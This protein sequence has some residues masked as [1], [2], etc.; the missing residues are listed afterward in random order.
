MYVLAGQH[1][2]QRTKYGKRL[3]ASQSLAIVRHTTRI[4]RFVQAGAAEQLQKVVQH[5]AGELPIIADQMPI[6]DQMFIVG[7][8]LLQHL[9]ADE[10]RMVLGQ[11]HQGLKYARLGTRHIAQLQRHQTVLDQIGYGM[12]QL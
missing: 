9:R 11:R 4:L 6:L 1:L 12:E 5:K 8:R 3:N 2:V 10:L 7:Q